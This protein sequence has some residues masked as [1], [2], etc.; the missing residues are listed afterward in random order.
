[1]FE[2]RSLKHIEYS[3]KTCPYYYFNTNSSIILCYIQIFLDVECERGYIRKYGSVHGDK[4][5]LL[6]KKMAEETGVYAPT[7]NECRSRCDK[8]QECK[9]YEYSP[10]KQKC[11]IR[12]VTDPKANTTGYE[13][14]RWCSKSNVFTL[15]T[16]TTFQNRIKLRY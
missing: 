7:D 14:Y 2:K 13:D 6:A 5:S 10:E 16:L 15:F 1:M 11:I 3:F 8:D 12:N 4:G 9:T